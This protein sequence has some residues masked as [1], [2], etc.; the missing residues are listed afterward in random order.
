MNT[1]TNQQGYW[2]RTL[3]KP[4]SCNDPI[5]GTGKK[6]YIKVVGIQYDG[7]LEVFA[8]L[9]MGEQ[10]LLRREPTNP[11]DYNA[12]LVE[13]LTGEQ[14]GYVKRTEAAHLAVMFDDIGEPVPGT[15]SSL[16]SASYQYPLPVV[17][18]GFT[19]PKP[20]QYQKGGMEG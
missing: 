1:N 7:R 3:R 6:I 17:Y 9:K 19:L 18:V 4:P 8:K 16:I 10:V 11:H 15:I 12:I 2:I 20:N 14:I 13:R 5:Y